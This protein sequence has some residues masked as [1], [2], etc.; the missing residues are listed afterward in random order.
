MVITTLNFSD[1][2]DKT[3]IC[4]LLIMTAYDYRHFHLLIS[5]YN[6]KYLCIFN[7]FRVS[8]PSSPPDW[9]VLDNEH[10][11]IAGSRPTHGR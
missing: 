4:R 8:N 5:R 3:V 9:V 2:I 10:Q 6:Y 1:N 11:S 7:A